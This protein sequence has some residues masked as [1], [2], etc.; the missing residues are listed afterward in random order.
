MFMLK[1]I[2]SVILVAAIVSYSV[3]VLADKQPVSVA[4]VEDKNFVLQ[5]S[6]NQYL[7]LYLKNKQAP[8][9]IYNLGVIYYKLKK[10]TLSKKFFS[11]LLP[12]DSY[13]LLA[14]YNL[15]L[16][17]FK[18]DDKEKAI[19]WFRN[20][21]AHSHG[22]QDSTPAAKKIKKLAKIQLQ[23][24]LPEMSYSKTAE[25]NTNSL[26]SYFFTYY[27]YDDGV[28]GLD[29]A[30][31]NFNGDEFTKFYGLLTFKLNSVTEGFETR[32]SYYLKDYGS[33]HDY[34][35]SQTG[36]DLTK[37]FKQQQW[38]HYFRLG[39]ASSTYGALDYQSA[40]RL[41][42]Q[43]QFKQSSHK[44]SVRYRYDD[45][46]SRD[47]TFDQYQGKRQRLAFIYNRTVSVHKL[48][49]GLEFEENDRLNLSNSSGIFNY[50][51]SRQKLQLAW[52]YRFK[53]NWESRLKYEYRDSHYDNLNM[54]AGQIR[55]DT[56]ETS[57]IRL[58]YRL[59][60]AWWL[61]TDFSYLNNQSSMVE[62][63]YSK[64]ILS[65][66]VNAAF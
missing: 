31:N 64:N 45:L 38:R 12:V 23:K 14:K 43:S 2:I 15:G 39:F 1:K 61:V 57:R 34:D 26:K 33:L 36:I 66:G 19:F 13:H 5:Q 28:T 35:F 27:G 62:Y 51:P 8:R 48:K 52:M 22:L 49:L 17:A 7:K 65:F 11:K 54:T 6:L 18:S 47:M 24:L 32:V 40:S 53:K 59:E 58:R 56:L 41:D 50:S 30:G 10:Y 46:I 63:S 4:S 3:S 25:K 55:D 9:V 21:N 37:H 29:P 60:K 20:I 44:Y 42:M 16:V